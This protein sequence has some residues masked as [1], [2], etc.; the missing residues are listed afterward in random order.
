M[1]KKMKKI[2]SNTPKVEKITFSSVEVVRK[3]APDS[4]HSSRDAGSDL[5]DS[6]NGDVRLVA[7]Y[8]R[9]LS[10]KNYH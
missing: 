4:T 6:K 7:K 10:F 3:F 9:I 1:E 2:S 5:F 8:G